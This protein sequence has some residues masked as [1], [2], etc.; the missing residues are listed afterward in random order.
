MAWSI[1]APA[2]AAAFTVV[3]PLV[4]VV[5]KV[6]HVAVVLT[7]LHTARLALVGYLRSV[8]MASL[9]IASMPAPA[10]RPRIYCT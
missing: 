6:A 9:L 10:A 1:G 2:E 7:K 3:L 5:P 4:N 8:G